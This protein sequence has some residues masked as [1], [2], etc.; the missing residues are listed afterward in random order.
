[1]EVARGSSLCRPWFR[2]W[3]LGTICEKNENFYT[4]FSSFFRLPIYAANI[5]ISGRFEYL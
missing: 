3:C 5:Q 1:M 4:S 2:I